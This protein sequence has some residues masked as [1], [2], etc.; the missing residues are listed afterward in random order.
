[1]PK[2]VG[3]PVVYPAASTSATAQSSP[4]LPPVERR[5]RRS[6]PVNRL[7]TISA[8]SEGDLER[9]YTG[10]LNRQST[11]ST[12]QGLLPANLDE[13]AFVWQTV[14][15][16]GARLVLPQSG[17]WRVNCDKE[18]VVSVVVLVTTMMG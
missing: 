16:A 17:R 13:D 11:G 8:V 5:R 3:L 7:S 2:R 4:V 12:Y 6:D 18:G 14:T 1:L 10:R 9:P 15:H